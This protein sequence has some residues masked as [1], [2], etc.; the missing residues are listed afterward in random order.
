L[1]LRPLARGHPCHALAARPRSAH[2]LHNF[3]F[4]Q[5]KLGF[6]NL[7]FFKLQLKQKQVIA[8]PILVVELSFSQLL[9][10]S[11]NEAEPCKRE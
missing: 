9:D 8:D 7:A 2:S 6:V 11:E 1:S 4:S 3:F 10:L 5:L